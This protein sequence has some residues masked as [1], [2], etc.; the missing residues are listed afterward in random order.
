MNIPEESRVL[1][2]EVD[3]EY[4]YT[5]ELIEITDNYIVTRKQGKLILTLINTDIG[6]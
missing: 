3:R 1:A 4:K 2:L 5:G 6:L